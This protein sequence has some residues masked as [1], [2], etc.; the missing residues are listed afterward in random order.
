MTSVVVAGLGA[1]LLVVSA[2]L[3]DVR[4]GLAVLG[5]IFLFAGLLVDFEADS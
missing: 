4:A 3:V 1:A 2:F 5:G